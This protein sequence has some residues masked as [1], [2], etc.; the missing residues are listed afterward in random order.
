MKN[1]KSKQNLFTVILGMGITFGIAALLMSCPGS[2][3]DEKTTTQDSL[4]SVKASV[5]KT[6]DTVSTKDTT[7]T[8]EV[9]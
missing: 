1:L 5:S 6:V 8:I 9:K 7:K 2:T 4:D 3:N